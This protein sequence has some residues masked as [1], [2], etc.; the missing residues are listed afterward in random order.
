MVANE[1]EALR[2]VAG[3]WEKRIETDA[4]LNVYGML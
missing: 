1:S 3:Q 4:I 2:W